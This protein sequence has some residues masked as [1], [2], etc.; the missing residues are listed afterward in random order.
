MGDHQ[1]QEGGGRRPAGQ[2]VRQA[3]QERRG[4]RA[5]RRRRSR[6]QPDPLRRHPEGQEDLGP[7]RQH[8]PRGQARLR[9]RGRRC[10]LRDADVRGVRSGRHRPADRVPDRQPE[11]VRLRRPGRGHPQRRH[12]GRRRLHRPDVQPQGRRDA[13][14]GAGRARP[15]PRTTCWRPP[16]TPTRRRS[17]ISATASR[18]SATPATP[19][20]SAPR[21]R[22]P[23]WTTTPPRSPSCPTTP[24]RSTRPTAEKLFRIIEALEDSDDVQNVYANF[25]ASDEVL[26]SVS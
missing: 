3:D 23:D 22:T 14:Q 21:C 13:G 17:T 10:R 19:S 15:S 4:R 16:W 8:R 26:A 6:R 7:Q 25:D 12:H 18:S 5:D 24:R 9:G 2:A 20:G 11:P 1:A